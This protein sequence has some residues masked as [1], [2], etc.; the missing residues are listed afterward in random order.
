MATVDEDLL[1]LI[2]AEA[3]ID[4]GKL[5]REATLADLGLD[6]VDVISIVFAVEEKY[7]VEIPQDAFSDTVDL[8]GFIDTLKD[9]VGKSGG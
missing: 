7:G 5:A 4:R 8:G 6:S 1:D 9:L 3:L 2:A